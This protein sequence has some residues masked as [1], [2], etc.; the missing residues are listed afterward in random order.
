MVFSE[1]SRVKIPCILHLVRLGY[2][3][4]SLKDATWDEETNIFPELFRTAIGQI[5]PG[6]DGG[7]IDRLLADVK[8][9]LDNEDLGKAFYEKLTER[10]GVRLIDFENF[11]N[12]S[13]HVVTELTCKNGDDEFR[14][15]ITLLINGM[16][17]SFIEVKKPNNREGVLA[18]RNRIITRSRNPRFR[19]FVNITQLMVFSNNMEYDDGSPQPIEGAF[20]ASPSYDSPVFN[21]FREEETLDLATLLAEENDTIENDVLRDNNLNVIK[22]SPE[23]ISN[24]S[25]DA[26]T[27]RVCTSLFSR[28]RLAFLLRFALV[29]V[30]ET[31]GLQKHV[32]R[33]PQ[34]FATKAIE[35]KLDAGV[36]KGI[37][38]HTQGSGK[39]AL[40]YYNTRFLTDYFQ[41]QG[42]IPKFYF[43]VDRLDLLIQAQRE[44]AARGLV[45]HS[46]DSREAFARDIKTTKVLHNNTG[47]P[48]ITVVNIQKF[49]DDPEVVRAE[50]YDVSIQRVY[51]LDEVHRSYNPQGSFLANLTQSDRNAIKI[52]LTGTPLLGD[53][54]NSR[55]LFGDYIHK[56]YYN[57]S[58]ADGY[59]LRLIREEIATNYKL[60]L[61]E[62]LASV[63]IQQGDID[64]KLIYAHP[65]FVEPMLDYIVRDFEKSRSALGEI[66]IGGM[67]I[68]DSAEQARQMFE[69]FSGV[70]ATPSISTYAVQD[71]AQA[72]IAAAEPGSYAARVLLENRAKSAA[73]ILHDVGTKEERKQWVE[74][75]KAGKIDLLF[76]YNMLLTGFDAKRLKK[77]YLG[78][79]IRSHNLL[80]ALTRVNRTYKDFRYGYVVDFADIRKEFDSTNK[81]YFDELQAELGDEVAHYSN[82]F[83]ST[84]E[85]A[86]EIEAI[87]DILFSFD[88]EN[89]E[90]FSQ[91]ITQ[92]Q[93]RATVLALKKALADARNLYNLIRLQGD[94]ALLQQLDFQK[95]NQ[96][97]R[98]TSNHLDLLNLKESIESSTD[99][100]NLLNIALEDV[101]F[102]FTKIKE[103]ELVLADKLKS[104]LRRTREALV[105]NFDQ[106][107]PKFITLREELERLFK[108]KK[109]NEV[110]QEEMTTNIGALNVIYDKIKE[111]N[112]QNNQ[113][114]AKYRGDVK[115]TRIHKRLQE[116]GSV[117]QTERRLF[118]ALLGVKQQAD[119]Q[120][121]QNTQ[122]LA[123]ESY[124]GRMMMPIVLD[125]FETRQKIDLNL[126]AADT[127]NNLVVNEY[128]NEF[129]S[130][131]RTGAQSW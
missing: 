84:E 70:Y 112:R 34:L 79:V 68:C 38:W 17:L 20:Y 111:L 99:T 47:K 5:N 45:V 93:D 117:T 12:N 108:K 15:D 92:I 78:R 62:A 21:Y 29:Y 18:E 83:K 116:R 109:L 25:P 24:K 101:L 98:E 120:V 6:I 127:I 8:L 74:D 50:D 85:I 90:V 10:S 129:A 37:I 76:V 60:I 39:T 56:Y 102:M 66:S 49:Q 131:S 69:I 14:P 4:L 130:G 87:K 121:L 105:D 65:K 91:Q 82:L 23:F 32:M 73:L 110:S 57:A 106:Q 107:D 51:F 43:I 9:L 86:Q 72:L 58:I 3:Y 67:V 95:L 46:I 114:R 125:E 71:S 128:M 94:N 61:R 100:S 16:P 96:L 115:F 19:R 13:F 64:R 122:L 80:Q 54:Y 7:D 33:Y 30:N 124:F 52:G 81:A 2:N 89:A 27:N 104:T 77:L 53:D 35:R 97:Y 119:E 36:R 113:L 1:D 42:I 41:H 75:F 88:I 22:H 59:T 48:E 126:D 40:A 44:F 11:D 26:P 103:E 118:E 63:E 123:N 28:D 55:A 31:D